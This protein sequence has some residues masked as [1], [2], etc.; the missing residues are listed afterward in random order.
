M[1]NAEWI[2]I[3]EVFNQTLDLSPTEREIFLAGHHESIRKEVRELINSHENADAFIKNPIAVNLGLDK[4]TN[5]GTTI[6]NYKLLEIIGAGGMGTVYLAERTDLG[7][8]VALKL[9]KRGMDTREVLKRFTLERQILSRLNHPNIARLLDAGSTADGLPYFVMEYIEGET[10]IKFCDNHDFDINE[11]LELFQKVC[12]AISYAHSNL[13]VHRDIKPSN[14][15]VTNDG[16]PKLLD[17]GIA[18]LLDNETENTATQARIFTPEYASPEQISGLPITTATDVYSL[19]VVL[20]Q[21]LSGVRPFASENRNYAEVAKM[22]LTV[23]PVRPSYAW[24]DAE[25]RR[26]GETGKE[27]HGDTEKNDQITASPRRRVATSISPDIDNIIL[28]SLRKEPDR[29]YQ[30]VNDFSEDIKRH[31]QGLPVTATADSTK[32]RVSKF[33][34]RHKRGVAISSIVGLLILAISGVAI[35]Q[36]I[37]ANRERATAERRTVETRKIANTL[38]FE[39]DE[40]LQELPGAT[41]ARELL[42]KRALE[43]LDSL[44]QESIDN[45]E[46]LKELS[47]AYRKVADI[48]GEPYR[49]NLSQSA[50]ALNNYLKAYEIQNKLFELDSDDI[51]LQSQLSQTTQSLGRLYQMTLFDQNKAFDF[52][53]IS[54]THLENICLQNPNDANS[55]SQLAIMYDL[56]SGI[57]HERLEIEASAKDRELAITL[58]EDALRIDPENEYVLNN[59]ALLF[60]QIGNELGNGDYNDSGETEK[61]LPLLQRALSLREKQ[62]KQTPEGF[63]N[64]ANIGVSLRDLG[65]VYM[66]Q[67]DLPNAV[68]SFQKALNIHEELAQKDAN[69]MLSQANVAFSSYKLGI[70]FIRVGRLD[71]SLKL[72]KHAVSIYKRLHTQDMDSVAIGYTYGI[73]LEKLAD[74]LFAQKVFDVA[75]ENYERSF[76]LINKSMG[77]ETETSTELLIAKSRVS[78]KLGKTKQN[79][80]QVCK[81]YL[82]DFKTSYQTLEKVKNDDH[83]SPTNNEYLSEAKK[84]FDSANC[85]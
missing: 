14:I 53:R 62:Y 2:K 38:M 61:A 16:T 5:V 22:V 42:V 17:F 11:R 18:K 37:V 60:S 52:F 69:G 70:A 79:L 40:S 66:A 3:K 7:Q 78:L 6:D 19:G 57:L 68:E 49:S 65:E 24:R 85:N 13:I 75:L 10:I 71:E 23:E 28:K 34:Q 73:S 33:V 51:N 9:I 64:Y 39:I 55:K 36:A 21:L 54:Q 32:Y 47:I 58:T 26:K 31:L 77:S 74:T 43:Y 63:T 4:D 27:R 80:N 12:S 29:R 56:T 45:P 81:T 25:T 83:L 35:W 41:K 67:K 82:S 59:S 50:E 46:L 1:Q 44:Y 84:L 20:Y 76:E 48:Q 72:N 8:K 15:I 30:T